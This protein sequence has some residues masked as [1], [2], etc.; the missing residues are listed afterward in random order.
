MVLEVEIDPYP[1]HIQGYPELCWRARCAFSYTDG[2]TAVQAALKGV[3]VVMLAGAANRF[4]FLFYGAARDQ[5]NRR[6]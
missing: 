3:D 1:F 6:S 4:V 2:R 5:E